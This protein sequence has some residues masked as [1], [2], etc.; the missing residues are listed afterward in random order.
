M[1][2]AMVAMLTTVTIAIL[3]EDYLAVRNRGD[4]LRWRN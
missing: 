3:L 2:V 4:L 1:V